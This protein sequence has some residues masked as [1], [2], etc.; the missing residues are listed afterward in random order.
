MGGYGEPVRVPLLRTGPADRSTLTRL[1]RYIRHNVLVTLAV[2]VG[3]VALSQLN[4]ES[5]T[6]RTVVLVCGL[7][8][9]VLYHWHWTGGLVLGEQRRM[10]WWQAGLVLTGILALVGFGVSADSSGVIW[11]L[12]AGLVGHDLLVGRFPTA[13]LRFTAPYAVLVALVVLAVGLARGVPAEEA[14]RSAGL[15]VVLVLFG[16]YGVVLMMRQ[17]H[18]S[19]ELEHARQAAAELATIKERL[20]LAEDLH[21]ILGHALEVVSL[22]SELASRLSEVDPERSRAELAEVQR[23]ARGAMHDVR[24]LVAGSRSTAFAIELAGVRGL[25]DSAGIELEFRGD[26][27][28]LGPVASELLGRVLREAVTNLLRHAHATRALVSL[29]VVDGKRILLVRND[30]VAP[31]AGASAAGSGLRGLERRTVE[32]GGLF[33]AGVVDG[34]GEFE[35]RAEVAR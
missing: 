4:E 2:V 3:V 34:T 8:G 13:G 12:I 32:A 22:K 11:C 14:W 23:L 15:A 35:V 9:V 26:A 30:G 27:A 10:P 18:I 33:S 31:L 28:E 7:A 29:E 5:G 20:R 21:D 1:R 24:A 6:V 25:L 19:M 17:W 16:I